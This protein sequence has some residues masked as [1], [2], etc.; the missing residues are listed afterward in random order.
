MLT[1]S[2][3]SDYGIL[4]ISSLLNKKDYVPLSELIKKTKLPKRYLARI[5]SILTK[6]KIIKSKEGKI[7]GYKLAMNLDK[8]NLFDYL[9]IFEGDFHLCKCHLEDYSCQYEHICQHQ[10]F[11]RKKVDDIICNQLKKIKLSQLIQ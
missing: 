10:I 6:N 2:N 1:I 9:K 11:F 4:L 3:Q 8:I 5:A 7:G